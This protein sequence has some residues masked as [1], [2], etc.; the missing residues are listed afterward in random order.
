MISYEQ[1]IIEY[2]AFK[3][4]ITSSAHQPG[5]VDHIKKKYR[6]MANHFFPNRTNCLYFGVNQQREA[7]KKVKTET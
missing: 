3:S 6:N 7:I 5:T 2:R 1:G 4:H